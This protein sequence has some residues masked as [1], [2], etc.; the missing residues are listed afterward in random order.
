MHWSHENGFFRYKN[1]PQPQKKDVMA[2]GAG[3]QKIIIIKNRKKK[4]F[5]GNIL[6]LDMEACNDSIL[7]SSYGFEMGT[8]L[9]SEASDTKLRFG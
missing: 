1:H 2:V 6:K 3:V 7:Y 4:I 9:F 5:E 8:C